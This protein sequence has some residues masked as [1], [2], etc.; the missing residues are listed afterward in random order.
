MT[1]KYDESD[2]EMPCRKCAE[3]SDGSR[4]FHL[5]TDAFNGRKF[6]LRE[7]ENEATAIYV[8]AASF[9]REKCR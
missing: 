5:E 7:I 3:V 1:V 8:S 6:F 9:R 4:L 2:D